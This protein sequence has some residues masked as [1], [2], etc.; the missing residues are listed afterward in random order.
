[1]MFYGNSICLKDKSKLDNLTPVTS[2][3]ALFE[4]AQLKENLFFGIVRTKPL[5]RGLTHFSE[6]TES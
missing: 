4:I 3:Q 2:D 1:M 6:W 5:Q